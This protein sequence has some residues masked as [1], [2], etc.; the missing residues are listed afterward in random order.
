MQDLKFPEVMGELA[1]KGKPFAVATVVKTFGSTLAKQGFKIVVDEKGEV[2]YG[3]LGGA[4]PEGAIVD[5]ALDSIRNKKPRLV[6]VFLEDVG[7]AVAAAVKGDN[8]DEIHVETNCGGNMEIFVDPYTAKDRLVVVSEGGRDDVAVWLVKFGRDVGFEVH[9]IDPSESIQGADF[10]YREEDLSNFEFKA[11]D[12]VAIVT[13]G[14][15]DT[16][17]L[18]AVSK[19]KCK[20]VGLMASRTRIKDDFEKLRALGVSEEFLSAVH[21]PVGA[22][23][24]AQTPQEIAASIIAELVAVKHGKHLPHK[25]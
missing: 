25:S 22:D 1:S 19:A 4:C 15:L 23:I 9:L 3:T 17:A 8:P 10:S 5:V 24:G 12:Y 14:R 16:Q 20:F 21:A 2:V 7:R 11:S 18:Q 6:K 13:R